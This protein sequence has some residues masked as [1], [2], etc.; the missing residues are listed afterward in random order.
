MAYL[1]NGLHNHHHM[2][3]LPGGHGSPGGTR[4]KTPAVHFGAT[5]T[6]TIPAAAAPPDV[7]T[8]LVSELLA[9]LPSRRAA[10]WPLARRPSL[11]L[12]TNPPQRIT[13]ALDAVPAPAETPGHVQ[14]AARDLTSGPAVNSRLNAIIMS[15]LKQQYRQAC[16][17]APTPMATQPPMS[18]LKP[19]HMPAATRLLE[20]PF[21][22]AARAARRAEA[23]G[24]GGTSGRRLDRHFAYSR[25]RLLKSYREDGTTTLQCCAFLRGFSMLAAGNHLGELQVRVA[26][27]GWWSGAGWV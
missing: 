25:F 21:N 20:A 26:G 19:F 6:V 7:P 12:L 5:T 10:A 3:P 16:M 2:T 24:F 22:M 23:G 13:S 1:S 11:E 4:T 14:A 27:A 9:A 18:L 15:Y 17:A 8:S